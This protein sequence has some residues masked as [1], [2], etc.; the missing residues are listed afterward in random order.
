LSPFTPELSELQR[1]AET[2]TG[3][4]GKSLAIGAIIAD[5][6]E[7]YATGIEAILNETSSRFVVEQGQNSLRSLSKHFLRKG[8]HLLILDDDLVLFPEH[9]IR[10]ILRRRPKLK[11]IVIYSK[12]IESRAKS[13]HRAGVRAIIRRGIGESEMKVVV[14]KVLQGQEY[15]DREVRGWLLQPV[16]EA[17]EMELLKPRK[18]SLSKRELQIVSGVM[19]GKRHKE[20]ATDLETSEQVIKNILVR[21]YKK[22]G[23]KNKIELVTMLLGKEGQAI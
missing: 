19:A 3:P 22:F 20:I 13:Y 5:S 8:A 18:A 14:V 6:S 15:Q 9:T 16:R 23:V 7:I 4:N 12:S 10:K 2:N 21:V 1:P 17:P 11:I